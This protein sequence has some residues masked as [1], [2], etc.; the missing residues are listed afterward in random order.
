V[1][2]GVGVG[3]LAGCTELPPGQVCER[4]IPELVELVAAKLPA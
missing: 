3:V 4:R 2:V 1:G